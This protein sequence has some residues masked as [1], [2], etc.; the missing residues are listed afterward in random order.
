MRWRGPFRR[1]EVVLFKGPYGVRISRIAAIPGDRIAM[2]RGVPIVNGNAAVQ[3]PDGQTT[4]TGYDG[5]HSAAMFSERLP[6]EPSAHRVLDTGPS[7]F[8]E[9]REVAVPANTLFVLGD[10]RDSSADSR[11]P[12]DLGGVGLVPVSAI[13]GR[14]MYIHWSDD[15][16]KIGMRLDR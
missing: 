9:M 3:S 6:S 1:G 14:P 5:S 11:V 16:S 4:F 2:R 10:N 8:D 15:R 12:S 7:E 13:I